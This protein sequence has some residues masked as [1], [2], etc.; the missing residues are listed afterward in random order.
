MPRYPAHPSAPRPTPPPQPP[1]AP[2]P[3]VEGSEGPVPVEVQIAPPA[4]PAS[5]LLT[6]MLVA[7]DAVRLGGA[8]LPL[9]LQQL[10]A[11]GR[12]APVIAAYRARSVLVA[13]RYINEH[14]DAYLELLGQTVA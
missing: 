4:E 1:L 13:Q 2:K 11:S 12:H 7:A 10:Q 8:E 9:S 14:L 3:R 5:T 6:D